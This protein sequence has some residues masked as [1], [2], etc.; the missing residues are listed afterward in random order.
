MKD[1]LLDTAFLLLIA[2][3]TILTHDIIADFI[4]TMRGGL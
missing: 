2:Y 3:A 4:H 1:T